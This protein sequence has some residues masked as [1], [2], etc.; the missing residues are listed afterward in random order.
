MTALHTP[1]PRPRPCPAQASR[2][3]GGFGGMNESTKNRSRV[4]A[5]GLSAP[6]STGA[7]A[8]AAWSSEGDHLALSAA[9]REMIEQK[10][11][12]LK[13]DVD[14]HVS[15]LGRTMFAVQV[16]FATLH[17]ASNFCWL[18]PLTSSVFYAQATR[19]P[20]KRK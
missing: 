17:F 4:G 20:T 7:D 6:F 5:D 14:Q 10:I 11:E 1:R 3:A 8:A 16:L 13:A 18:V 12:R 15:K 2:G 19:R 9:A